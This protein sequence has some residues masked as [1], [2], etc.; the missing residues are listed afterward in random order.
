VATHARKSGIDVLGDTPWGTHFCVFYETKQDLL[1]TLV[2]YFKAG[3]EAHEFCVW[4]ISE[5]LTGDEVRDALARGIPAFDRY[6]AEGSMD[7]LPGRE[8]YLSGDRFDMQ[9]ITGG[10]DAKLRRALNDGYEGMRVSGNAFWLDSEHWKDFC[11]Y[12]RELDRSIVDLPMT[13]L[14][15]YP[16]PASRAADILDVARAHQFT[17]AKR[18]GLWEIIETP[19]LKQ[20][21]EEIKKLNA[22]LEQRVA[23]RTREL[24]AVNEE[25]IAEAS[26]RRQ[27]E[28]A[29]REAQAEIARATRVT[30]MGELAA[31]IA[32]EI[33]Q[34]LAAIVTNSDASLRWLANDPPNLDEARRALGR[35]IRDATRAG[36]VIRRIRALLAKDTAEHVKLGLNEA[37]RDVVALMRSTLQAR[38]VTLRTELA[39]GLPPVRGDK[40]QLQQV[41]MN[42]IVNGMEAMNGVTDRPRTLA[43]RSQVAQGGDVLVAVEDA[44]PGLEPATAERI[45]DPFFTTKRDGMGMGLAISRSIVEA[46]GG[47]LWASPGCPHG[48]VFRFTVPPAAKG[49]APGQ[50]DHPGDVGSDATARP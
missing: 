11:N 26:E 35:T 3:L 45:F 29:L 17:L 10:W 50:A 15:T 18:R 2:P 8:W 44:G 36:N 46:H 27:A 40:V 1:D 12:E 34:P 48:T 9:K 33:N 30:T 41:I 5:P 20:A 22:E 24:A 28:E 19:E 4:A 16:L 32:H 49:S 25:L 37:V 39:A 7:I 42:L 13:V 38:Q 14:C 6:L 47:R 31:S 23:E 43:V 21:K